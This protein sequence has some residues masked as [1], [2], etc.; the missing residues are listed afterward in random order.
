LIK[1]RCIQKAKIPESESIRENMRP[2]KEPL[3]TWTR[4]NKIRNSKGKWI[5]RNPLIPPGSLKSSHSFQ[6]AESIS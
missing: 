3:Y 4:P 1:K 2:E 5:I 6:Y